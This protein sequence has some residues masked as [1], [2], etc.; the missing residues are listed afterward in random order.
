MLDWKDSGMFKTKGY[1][2]WI[3]AAENPSKTATQTVDPT[4]LK[5][6]YKLTDQDIFSELSNLTADKALSTNISNISLKWLA[7]KPISVNSNAEAIAALKAQIDS[8]VTQIQ[9]ISSNGVL[10]T[11]PRLSDARPPLAHTQGIST[12]IGLADQ[13]VQI[14][15][16]IQ[17]KQAAGNYAL[18]QTLTDAIASLN[19]AIQGKQAAGNYALQQ[20]LTD[21]ITTLQNAISGKQP[22]GNYISEGDGRLTDNRIPKA[23]NQDISTINGLQ[24]ALDGKQAAGDYAPNN[25]FVLEASITATLENSWAKYSIATGNPAYYKDAFGIVTLTGYLK[26]GAL[27]TVA[28]HL[29]TGYLPKVQKTY[30][31]FSGN[32]PSG[33]PTAAAVT[34]LT[35]GSVTILAGN[36]ACISLDGIRFRTT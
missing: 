14:A 16:A 9:A 1:L 21:A 17:G 22:I 25:S 12:I 31:V 32:S 33:T 2:Y 35:D 27:G 19:T 29:P 30:S 13:L 10:N 3:L 15:Q 20:A 6:Y 4:R 36:N 24:T 8:L 23:H 18:Q 11:D 5:T 34:V 28:F 7:T 26:A